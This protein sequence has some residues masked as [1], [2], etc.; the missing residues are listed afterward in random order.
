[1][2]QKILFV[3]DEPNILAG[4]ERLFRKDYDLET[5]VSGTDALAKIAQNGPYAVLLSDMRMP[6]M[7]GGELLAAA[8]DIA[9][10]TVR[11][12]L[13]GETDIMSA[14][15][16]VNEGAIFRF[17]LKP[18]AEPAMRAALDA[19]LRQYQLQRAERDLLEQTLRGCIKVL[20]ELLSLVNPAA[21]G[22]SVRIQRYVRHAAARLGVDDAWQYEV[23]AMLSQ[24][25]CVTLPAGTIEALY[26]GEPLSDADRQRYLQHASVGHDLLVQIPRL[27]QV[28][29][30][31]SRQHA[32][33][34]PDTA[35]D[36]VALGAQ[37]LKVSMAFDERV[38]RGELP[39]AAVSALL[40]RSAEYNPNVVRSLADV[41]FDT[42]AYQPVMMTIERLAA[43]MIIDQ[44]VRTETGMLLVGRGQETT[45]PMLVRLRNFR[46][47][48]AIPAEVRV[49]VQRPSFETDPAALD[50][51]RKAS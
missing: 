25:G 49:L 24:I 20:T 36:P 6:R 48:G 3:D 46:Q 19:A 13:T 28:A 26:A 40:A 30:M 32:A 31:I 42:M 4:F 14:M 37:I 38:S 15:R 21:F 7:S 43:G 41:T 5:A 27:E 45:Y 11:M 23:A 12:V 51:A 1:M 47:N 50:A 16:A 35:H 44:E 29:M 22:R 10:T 17:L 34:S 9:P 18:C 8:R 2:T 39:Q 33:F